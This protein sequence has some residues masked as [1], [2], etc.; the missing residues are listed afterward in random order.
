MLA[1]AVTFTLAFTALV[2][3]LSLTDTWMKAREAFWAVFEERRLLDAGF[4]PQVEASE[5]RMRRPLHK[6]ARR[7]PCLRPQRR[8]GFGGL[9]RSHLGAVQA[10]G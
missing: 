10:W 9:P 3:L 5:L 6:N 4:V 1:L 7:A 8:S 2:A